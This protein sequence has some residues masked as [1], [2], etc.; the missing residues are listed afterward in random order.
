MGDLT[1][2]IFALPSLILKHF[3]PLAYLAKKVFFVFKQQVFKV[4]RSHCHGIMPVRNA[5]WQT[6]GKH[7]YHAHP[8]LAPHRLRLF[9]ALF[10]NR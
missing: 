8:P 5:I 7:F 1:S 9:R 3:P 4:L 10:Q 6:W 2:L